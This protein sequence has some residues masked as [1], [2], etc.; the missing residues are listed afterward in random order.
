[1][2][3]DFTQEHRLSAVKLC[4]KVEDG[5]FD[6]IQFQI[7]T[8]DGTGFSNLITLYG[9]G[10]TNKNDP[11]VN[12]RYIRMASD[13]YVESVTVHYLTNPESSG[14]QSISLKTVKGFE[15]TS[16]TAEK[17]KEQHHRAGVSHETPLSATTYFEAEKQLV[18]VFG[19]QA[20]DN[21]SLNSLG[22]I[23][24]EVACDINAPAAPPGA[25]EETKEE[26]ETDGNRVTYIVLY[27]LLT[28]ILT[29]LIILV[30]MLRRQEKDRGASSEKKA[31]VSPDTPAGDLPNVVSAEK[32][33]EK[34][35]SVARRASTAIYKAIVDRSDSYKEQDPP[36]G[37]G[38]VEMQ[39]ADHNLSNLFEKSQDTFLKS[40]TRASRKNSLLFGEHNA[41]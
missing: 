24:F 27:A 38:D 15:L 17:S 14:I 2:A 36:I 4:E 32:K 29:V 9:H 1:M 34:R 8:P 37:K 21:S 13:D 16:G 31:A 7:G 39:V 28:L 23:T 10:N 12:C 30:C 26:D 41:S 19:L 18:G 33:E 20:S 6:G 40:M 11:A 5:D 22:F 35:P 25:S 3:D